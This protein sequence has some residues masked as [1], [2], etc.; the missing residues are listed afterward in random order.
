MQVANPADLFMHVSNELKPPFKY[1][2]SYVLLS[3]QD[4]FV[5]LLVHC[6]KGSTKEKKCN[7]EISDK[8]ES[9]ARNSLKI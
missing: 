4:S 7:A 9:L 8:F 1:L 2:T 6:Q 5:N 3:N